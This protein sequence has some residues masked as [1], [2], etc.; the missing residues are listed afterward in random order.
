MRT[1]GKKGRY[2]Y[3]YIVAPVG[4]SYARGAVYRAYSEIPEEERGAG[5]KIKRQR[6][7]R[8]EV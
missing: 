6:V 7:Y 4:A 2:Y 8:E 5:Y 1:I 3:I